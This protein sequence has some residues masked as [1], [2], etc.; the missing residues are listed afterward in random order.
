M[1]IKDI[2][3]IIDSL[4][5]YISVIKI[6]LDKFSNNLNQ[7]FKLFFHH[8]LIL[9]L[10]DSY[11]KTNEIILNEIFKKYKKNNFDHIINV[12]N[13]EKCLNE[14]TLNCNRFYLINDNINLNDFETLRNKI[15]N[16]YS[17]QINILGFITNS[18]Y[19]FENKLKIYNIDNTKN[20]FDTFIKEK[21]DLVIIDNYK[22]VINLKQLLWNIH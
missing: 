15:I 7:L 13:I 1:N 6:D 8:N 21:Y 14:I 11:V 3:K 19:I 18:N 4:C 20:I 17:Q 5:Q 10:D 12:I 9:L 22:L 16:K 2:I